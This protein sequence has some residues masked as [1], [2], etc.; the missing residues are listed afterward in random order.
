MKV[1]RLQHVATATKDM[2]AV[3]NL[4]ADLFGLKT[5]HTEVF[6][7]LGHQVAMI[8]IGDTNIEFVQ[9]RRLDHDV[10][11]W[12]DEKGEGLFHLCLEVESLD[13]AMDELRKKGIEFYF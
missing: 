6:E 11:K 12:I 4:F 8:P 1:I 2:N 7:S 5:T 10:N 13:E 3:S 9:A